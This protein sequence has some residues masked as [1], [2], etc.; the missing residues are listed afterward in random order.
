MYHMHRPLKNQC[1]DFFFPLGHLF[2]FLEME[3][4]SLDK[5]R[6]TFRSMLGPSRACSQ[7]EHCVTSPC[8]IELC[9]FFLPGEICCPHCLTSQSFHLL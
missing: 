8:Y 2:H 7:Q 9:S 4:L 5:C 3:Q 1:W 6:P